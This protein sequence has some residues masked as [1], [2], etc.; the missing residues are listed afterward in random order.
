MQMPIKDKTLKPILEKIQAGERLDLADGMALYASHDMTGIGSL[1]DAVRRNRH[2]NK[3]FFVYNQHVNYTNACINR[4][5]FCAFSKN[6]GDP[7]A[8]TLSIEDVRE[9]L[10][11]RIDEPITEIHMVGGLNPAL[12]FNYYIDLLETIKA[13]RPGATI[14]AFTA[15]EI[16]YFSKI[17]GMSL[18]ETIAA[19]KQAGL[20]MTPGGGAEVMSDRVRQKLFP[21]KTSSDRWLAVITELHGAGLTSNATM[22]YGHIETIE[23]R[24][25]HLIRLRELQDKTGGFS[26]FIPLAFHS[27]NTPLDHI[28]RTTAFDDLKTIAAARLILDNFVHI[29]AYW[30]MIGEKLAQ[31][32]LAYGAD[33]LDG[34]IIEEKITHMA[35]A[36]SAKGLTRQQMREMIRAAGF[37]SVERDSFYRP[38]NA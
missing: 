2:G 6:V 3:A 18:A 37:E 7:S 10:L 16:D 28:P 11:A 4:C 22:L 21:R 26:A 29:K 36:T 15:V 1:A 33:D 25:A 12:P 31:V 13:I 24:V 27:A 38:I 17:S 9:K 8:F 32:A 30:V 35:G 23:E 5:R 34:T 19:L 14:K 20:G